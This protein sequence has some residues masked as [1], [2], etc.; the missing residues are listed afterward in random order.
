MY[1]GLTRVWVGTP[2][3]TGDMEQLNSTSSVPAHV[4]FRSLA[5]GRPDSERHLASRSE[6]R[7]DAC[8][9]LQVGPTWKACNPGGVAV[10]DQTRALKGGRWIRRERQERRCELDP[11]QVI[12]SFRC[13]WCR[14]GE[15]GLT[16]APPHRANWRPKASKPS[17]RGSSQASVCPSLARPATPRRRRL[18]LASRSPCSA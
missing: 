2:G 4:V 3:M 7:K 16:A 12:M 18:P 13:R 9:P 6:E 5:S 11:W 17:P 1:R 8:R 15:T 14:L 10:L